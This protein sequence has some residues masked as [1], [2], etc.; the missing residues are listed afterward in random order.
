MKINYDC[1]RDVLIYLENTLCYDELLRCSAV[2]LEELCASILNYSKQ[3]IYYSLLMLSEA[4][5]ITARAVNSDNRAI[6]FIC[7]RLTFEGHRYLDSVKSPQIWKEIK[8]TFKSKALELSV[9]GV[10]ALA[11]KLIFD[12]L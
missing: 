9:D 7:Y 4:G 5:F 10:L 1:I 3:D 11:K 12:R 6:D 2:N 8:E